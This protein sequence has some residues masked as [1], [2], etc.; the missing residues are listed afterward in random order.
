MDFVKK[1][2]YTIEDLLKVV[3]MLRDPVNGC[4]WDRV[5]THLSVRKDFIEETYEAVDAID[6]NDKELMLEEFGDVMLQV[7]LHCQMEK[8]Q[9]S[10][11]FEDVVNALAQKLVLRHPHVFKGLEVNGV[12]DVLNNWEAIK[13]DSHGHTTISQ[14]VNAVPHSFPSLMYAQKVQKRVA[15]GGL[16]VPDKKEEIANIR[17]ILDRLENSQTAD[18][19]Q[20]GDL[21]FS[22]VNLVRQNKM[23]SEM[24]LREKNRNFV[25][26]FNNFENLALQKDIP[27]DT[28]ENA[29]FKEL[30]IQAQKPDEKNKPEDKYN[31]KSRTYRTC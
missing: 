18:E 22:C 31:D 6:N 7:L 2:F 16:P 12:E 27:F 19:A 30:W 13:N 5:Q 29:T 3:E 23:D 17:A 15:A 1:D 25:E 11:T 14:T 4:E 10:F 26:I 24:V 28:M 21:L 8:E 9:G 20:L